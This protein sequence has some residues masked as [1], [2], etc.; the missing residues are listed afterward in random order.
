[1]TRALHKKL[2]HEKVTE[3]CVFRRLTGYYVIS[4][5]RHCINVPTKLRF[6][7]R[8]NLSVFSGVTLYQEKTNVYELGSVSFEMNSSPFHFEFYVHRLQHKFCI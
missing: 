7:G 3:V 8:Q 5:V 6:T 2:I 4:C 1:M